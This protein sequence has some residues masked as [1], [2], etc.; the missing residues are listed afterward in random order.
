[1]ERT[2]IDIPA[3]PSGDVLGRRIRL[4]GTETALLDREVGSVAGCVEIV[5]A[6]DPGVLVDRNEAAFV[7]RKASDAGALELGERN[8]SVH[9][10]CL[11]SRPQLEVAVGPLD[12][13][14]R[15]LL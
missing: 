7:A 11:A 8:H 9:G 2:R 10:E 5:G 13:P 1:M 3:E 12:D 14:D 4:L 6:A 15:R